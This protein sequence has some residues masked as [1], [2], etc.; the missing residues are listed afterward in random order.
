MAA[1]HV[2]P[3][4][5]P[6]APGAAAGLYNLL[7][8]QAAGLPNDGLFARM[9]AS[10]AAGQSALPAGL[11]LGW[12]DFRAL[13]ARHFPG[14]GRLVVR[15]GR[16]AAAPPLL[17]WQPAEQGERCAEWDE[18]RAL[19]LQHR[20]A[21]DASE[22]WLAGIVATACMGGDHLWQD[23]GLDARSELSVLMSRN[24]P[25]L[26]ALNQR[27]MKWKRFLYKQLCNSAGVYVCRSPSCE[28]CADY[29]QC[30]GHE[31]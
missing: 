7:M 13:L 26:T 12:S 15:H 25:G 3:P 24:F 21:A 11:G 4:V 2:A 31:D 1:V 17:R 16:R 27:D 29:A 14:Y 10:Q 19:L 18:L 6:A 30:F 8:A 9:L 22:T 23:L 20:A 28:V 5:L